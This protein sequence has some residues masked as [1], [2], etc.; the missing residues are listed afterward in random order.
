MAKK[1]RATFQKQEKERARQQKQH[2]KAQRRLVAKEQR[3][4]STSRLE[5]DGL[6]LHNGAFATPLCRAKQ[7]FSPPQQG[8]RRKAGTDPLDIGWRRANVSQ[9]RVRIL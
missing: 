4:S 2:D 6:E 9:G 5:D 8:M 1:A 3:A 7:A